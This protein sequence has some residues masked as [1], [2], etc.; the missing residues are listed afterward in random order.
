[1]SGKTALTKLLA[2]NSPEIVLLTEAYS[3]PNRFLPLM[4][5]YIVKNG[6]CYNQFAYG[7]QLMFMQ[8]RI[9][10][11]LMCR[12]PHKVYLIDRSIYEDRHIFAKLF[13]NLGLLEDSEYNDYKD[14]FEKIVRNMESP[15]CFV[16]LNS[17]PNVCYERLRELNHPLDVW[18]TRDII[19]QMDELYRTRL[20]ERV[21]LYNPD[22]K[23]IEMETTNYPDIKELAKA[24]AIELNKV[25]K[26]KFEQPGITNDRAS[27]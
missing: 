16:L 11:E 19:K 25:Y 21:L 24:T 9:R 26:G 22:I 15:D 6:I 2:E 1:M 20:K 8:N 10:R 12:D 27:A 5:E 13:S 14:M 4:C 7:T 18:M 17:D 3:L 23:L